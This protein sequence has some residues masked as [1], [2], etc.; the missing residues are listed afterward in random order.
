MQERTVPAFPLETKKLCNARGVGG[1]PETLEE[2]E[3]NRANHV[4]LE[5]HEGRET[6]RALSTV[7]RMKYPQP[8]RALSAMRTP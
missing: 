3:D 8:V 6:M 5:D 1:V 4:H 7:R 2:T